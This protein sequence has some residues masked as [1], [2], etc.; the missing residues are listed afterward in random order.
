M[1]CT[2]TWVVN[3][4]SLPMMVM[5]PLVLQVA[6][7]AALARLSAPPRALMA[8]SRTASASLSAARAAP[9]PNTRA[10][11]SAAPISLVMRSPRLV[12]GNRGQ[13]ATCGEILCPGGGPDERLTGGPGPPPLR[14]RLAPY[15]L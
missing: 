5:V 11:A 12:R 6:P 13:R 10:S 1:P 9:E 4:F 8:L 7:L 3:G 15:L 14:P 2:V